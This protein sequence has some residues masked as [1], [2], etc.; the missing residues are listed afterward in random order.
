MANESHPQTKKLMRIHLEDNVAIVLTNLT[1]GERVEFE[2]APFVAPCDLG[3]GH[4]IA[5][6]AI[7]SGADVVKYGVPI[8]YANTD[9]S[10]GNHVHLH[11][12]CSRYTVIEDME[13][14]A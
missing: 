12:I 13:A 4:K 7:P 14:S 10:A 8:G 1:K 9:I 6:R 11:N 5:I 3:L 2:G